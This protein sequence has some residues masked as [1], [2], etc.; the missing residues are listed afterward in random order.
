MISE[1]SYVEINEQ[2]LKLLLKKSKER[3]V[4][5]FLS[6]NGKKW[7]ELYDYKK[8]ILVAFCQG[9]AMHYYDKK[10]GVKDFDIWFFYPFNKKDLPYRARWE[11]DFENKKFGQH[12]E[13]QKYKGR[14]IDVM[15]RSIKTRKRNPVEVMIEYLKE[16]KTETAKCLSK[17]AVVVL[18]PEEYFSKVIWY[19]GEDLSENV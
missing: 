12:P 10:N 9:A 16:G 1:R 4:K 2:D 13:M 15:V 5:F 14:K 8:P 18:E 19:K 6:N 7:I 17:K 3:L 11:C